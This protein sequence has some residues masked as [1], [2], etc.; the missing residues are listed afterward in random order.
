MPPRITLEEQEKILLIAKG[1]IREPES[2][3]E[4][5]WKCPLYEDRRGT[6]V[7]ARDDNGQKLYQYCIHGAVNE[8]TLAVLGEKRAAVV[9]AGKVTPDGDFDIAAEA[10]SRR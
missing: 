4:G 1:L 10:P 7:H 3:T 2:W 9:G 8:A 6:L 5:T